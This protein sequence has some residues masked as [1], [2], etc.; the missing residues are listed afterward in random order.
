MKLI[1]PHKGYHKGSA[2]TRQPDGTSPCI[3]NVRSYDS[4]DERGRGGQR[5]ASQKW[6]DTQAGGTSP[7]VEMVGVTVVD[8]V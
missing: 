7:V 6:S 1:F 5:P 3:N 2:T 8:S 4:L